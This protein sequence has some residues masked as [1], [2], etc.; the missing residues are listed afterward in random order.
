MERSKT[1]RQ[2]PGR[3]RGGV[4]AGERIRDYPTLT[5]RIPPETRAML[6]ALCSSEKLPA[7]QM[8]RQ[9]VVCFVRDLPVRRRRAIVRG[10]KALG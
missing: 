2:G 5:V 7:W 9:L 1:K 8:I 3:P 10:A 4:R 6:R